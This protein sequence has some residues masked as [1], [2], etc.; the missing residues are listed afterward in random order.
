MIKKLGQ[1]PLRSNLSPKP[2]Q[3]SQ[4]RGPMVSLGGGS[5][6]PFREF[7]MKPAYGRVG[8][9]HQFGGDELFNGLQFQVPGEALIVL[10]NEKK[11]HLEDQLRAA[12][13][14]ISAAKIEELRQEERFEDLDRTQLAKMIDQIQRNHRAELESEINTLTVVAR[15]LGKQM[16]WEPEIRHGLSFADVSYL[17]DRDPLLGHEGTL[18]LIDSDIADL[19]V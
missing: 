2:K 8:R 18:G 11:A 5:D 19:V 1:P 6:S 3:R 13:Q 14:P 9:R 16:E 15:W 4:S 17:E 10:V 7:R 12:I